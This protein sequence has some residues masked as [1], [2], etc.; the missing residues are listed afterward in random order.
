MSAQILPFPA[1]PGRGRDAA[2][3]TY[4]FGGCPH[5]GQND[6]YLNDGRDHWFRCDRHKV[7]W[8]VGS[9]LFSSW[10]DEDEETWRLNRFRLAEYMT[11]SPIPA[12]LS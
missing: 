6:G 10:R 7:K 2:V 11:V 12:G 9:N 1:P 3:T 4:P 8:W 5:C